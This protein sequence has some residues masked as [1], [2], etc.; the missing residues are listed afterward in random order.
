MKH[1]YA[2][3]KSEYTGLLASMR[4]T[5]PLQIDNVARKL[6]RPENLTRYREVALDTGVPAALIAALDQRE[7]GANPRAALGQGDPWNKV[8]THVPR[9]KGPWKSWKDAAVYYVNYDHLN[10]VTADR[11]DWTYACWKGEAWNG[12]GPRNHGVR[13]G[14]LWSGTSHYVKGKYVKDGVWD[15]NFVDRQL[16]IVPLMFR[17]VTLEPSLDFDWKVDEAAKFSQLAKQPELGAVPVGVG[18]EYGTE[19][20]QRS[21]NTAFLP[22]DE[23]LVVDGS[24]GRRTREAVRAFQRKNDLEPD[25]LFGPK[26]NAALVA[27]IKGVAT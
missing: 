26:T 24:Y 18:G 3:L 7:S 16:G 21:L 15:P 19:W 13:T 23:R 10:D 12:F 27:A 5:Q 9:G 2:V 17:M 14:Y 20:L 4:V 25:G 6:L 1:P 11:W 8:S 22:A